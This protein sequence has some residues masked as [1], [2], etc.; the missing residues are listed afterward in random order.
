MY[1]SIKIIKNFNIFEINAFSKKFNFTGK[2]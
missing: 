1:Q 2:I